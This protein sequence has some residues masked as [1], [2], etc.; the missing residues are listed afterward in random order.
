[1]KNDNL[2]SSKKELFDL[3]IKKL[4]IKKDLIFKCVTKIGNNTNNIKYCINYYSNDH[5]QL[6]QSREFNVDYLKNELRKEKL[7]KIK[8]EQNNYN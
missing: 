7:N 4:R 5:K 1:M 6:V 3:L 8:N 2:N